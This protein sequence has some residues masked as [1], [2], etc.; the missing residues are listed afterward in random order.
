MEITERTSD[1]ICKSPVPVCFS[2]GLI[3][4]LY[5]LWFHQT[6]CPRPEGH[7]LNLTAVRSTGKQQQNCFLRHSWDLRAMG[8]EVVVCPSHSPPLRE[9]V[10][11]C[12]EDQHF[13]PD[14]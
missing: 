11:R 7:S 1:S 5:C 14:V 10:E 2:P 4:A 6:Q 13:N 3:F 12:K 8:L 9:M